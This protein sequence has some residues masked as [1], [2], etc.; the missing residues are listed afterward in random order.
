MKNK[1]AVFD[2]DMTIKQFAP[3]FT[4][5][6]LS[7]LFPNQKIPSE[8]LDIKKEMRWD[9]FSKYLIEKINQQLKM[10]KKDIIDSVAND[11]ELITGMDKLIKFL[12]KDHDII[13]ISGCNVE[14]IKIFLENYNLLEF[15]TD[16]FSKPSTITEC[17]KILISPLPKEW[18]EFCKIT[19]R[20]FCK[21][22]VLQYFLKDRNYDK[23]LYIGDGENDLCPALNLSAK[24]LVCP[25]KGYKLDTKIKEFCIQAQI[26]PWSTGQDILDCV[27]NMNNF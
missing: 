3:G 6:G 15:I 23:I 18:G 16:I 17:G 5:Q 10:T 21:A 26:V 4:C 8:I 7:N 27:S 14:F 24:D 1:L 9:D 11:G 2:F 13:I 19:N 12:S 22:A 20:K 25:R